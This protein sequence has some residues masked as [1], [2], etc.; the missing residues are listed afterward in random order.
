MWA[1]TTFERGSSFSHWDEVV[2]LRGSSAAL[3]T[4][5]VARGEAY[6]DPGDITC[7]F[8]LDMGW[9]L[10]NGCSALI[11]G[12]GAPLGPE[13]DAFTVRRAGRNPVR[14]RTAIDVLLPE[15][16]PLRVALYDA[17]GRRVSVLLDGPG[18]FRQRVEVSTGDLASGVY[19]LV[20]ETPDDRELVQLTVLR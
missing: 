4:P 13:V 19:V 15:E 16:T 1:P 6:R 7:A 5:R 14:D 8:F 11:G 9:R 10:G 2:F 12:P 17:L 20:V 3:M 18:Q